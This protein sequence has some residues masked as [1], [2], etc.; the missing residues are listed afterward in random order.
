[1]VVPMPVMNM[2]CAPDHEL[3]KPRDTTEY[4]RSG[5]PRAAC[6]C[7]WPIHLGHD[8]IAGRISVDLR[9]GEEPEEVLPEERVAPAR[10][11]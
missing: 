11:L 4:T 8:A 7:C 9:V 10:R 2:W 5:S 6:G 3:M 1:M